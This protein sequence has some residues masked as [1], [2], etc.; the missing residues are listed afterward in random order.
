ML[1]LTHGAGGVSRREFLRIGALGMSGLSLPGLLAAQEASSPG[2]VKDR[3]VVLLF[4][5]G[6]PSHIETFDPKMTAPSEIRSVTGEVKTTLPGVTFG[7]TFVRMARLAHKLAVIRNL[8]HAAPDHNDAKRVMMSGVEPALY[9]RPREEQNRDVLMSEVTS[10]LCG[11]TAAWTGMPTSLVAGPTAISSDKGLRKD[12]DD[13]FRGSGQLGPSHLAFNPAG[14]GNL[15]QDMQLRLPRERFENRRELLRQLDGLRNALDARGAM[16][17]Q[18]RYLQQAADVLLGGISGV[19]DLSKES[20]ATLDAYDTGMFAIPSVVG[21][22][23]RRLASPVHLGKQMLLARRLC[24][25]GAR[26]V[27]VTSHGWDHHGGND[28]RQH[29]LINMVPALGGAVDKAVAAFIEDCERRGLS[30]KILLVVTGEFGRTPRLG[31]NGGRDHW[32]RLTPAVLYGG[33]LK[34]GQ[35]IGQSDR[36]A[37]E[38]SGEGYTPQHLMATIMHCLFD[39]GELR[40]VRGLPPE[41]VRRITDVEPIRELA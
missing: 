18:D 8:T 36:H 2:L 33:G 32:S 14:S 38:P 19:F 16:E 28:D 22:R 25:A 24:E 10:K 20:R 6:G 41:V 40:V 12:H 11:S 4:L 5:N 37:G 29:N 23:P 27:T 9:A 30:D 15:L 34:M 13:E 3:S 31:P 21:E 26:F 17:A 7:S 39:L 1:T 35:V